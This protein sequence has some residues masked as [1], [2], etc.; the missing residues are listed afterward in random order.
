MIAAVI[1]CIWQCNGLDLK[2]HRASINNI[3]K[4]TVAAQIEYL[5]LSGSSQV[6]VHAFF[7]LNRNTKVKDIVLKSEYGTLIGEQ[8]SGGKY[9]SFNASPQKPRYNEEYFKQAQGN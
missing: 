4:D 6:S 7:T 2:V 9:H 1:I 5:L 3:F 8:V